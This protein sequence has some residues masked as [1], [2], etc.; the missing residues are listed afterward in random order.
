MRLRRHSKNQQAA[1]E[2]PDSQCACK[3]SRRTSSVTTGRDW[4]SDLP[5]IAR[6]DWKEQ[7]RESTKCRSAVTEENSR[8]QTRSLRLMALQVYARRIRPHS[9]VIFVR[10]KPVKI[11]RCRRSGEKDAKRERHTGDFL[12]TQPITLPGENCN[13]E[14]MMSIRY[15]TRL[16]PLSFTAEDIMYQ[17]QVILLTTNRACRAR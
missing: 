12:C 9:S 10:Y 8:R 5:G 1:G 6:Q 4:L 11:A 15:G 7:M 13:F 3:K 16:S 14:E 2:L 17:E